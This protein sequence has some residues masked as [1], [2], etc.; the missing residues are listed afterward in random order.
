MMN[1]GADHDVHLEH[2][3]NCGDLVAADNSDNQVL[4]AD[5][6]FYVA[7]YYGSFPIIGHA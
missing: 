4:C 6:F 3:V 5:C 2:C 1:D 7:R